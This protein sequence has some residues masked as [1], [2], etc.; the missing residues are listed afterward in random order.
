MADLK[1][2]SVY[3][4][5]YNYSEFDFSIIKIAH[6]IE[7]AMQYICNQDHLFYEDENKKFKMVDIVQPKDTNKLCTDYVN[8]CYLSNG[9]YENLN[10]EGKEH[11]SPYII[12]PMIIE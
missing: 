3:T 11:I 10:I 9:K 7:A 8:I 4:I 2:K 6:S 12:V 5:L 1:G